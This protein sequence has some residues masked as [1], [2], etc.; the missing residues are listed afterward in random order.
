MARSEKSVRI[1]MLA[2]VVGPD[3]ADWLA[4]SEHDAPEPF[5]RDL[6][7]RRRA[8]VVVR[9]SPAPQPAVEEPQARRAGKAK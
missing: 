8:E 6:L 7:R 9:M 2:S 1:R 4:G 3:G 5:A